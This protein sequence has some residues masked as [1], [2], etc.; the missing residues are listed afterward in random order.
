MG[1]SITRETHDKLE[2]RRAA[3][4]LCQGTGAH[5]TA[6]AVVTVTSEN[7]THAVGE[8]TPAVSDMR[9]C[10]RHARQ[11]PPGYAGVNFRV[12]AVNPVPGPAPKLPQR[13]PLAFGITYWGPLPGTADMHVQWDG[14]GSGLYL[15]AGN[16]ETAVVPG[17]PVRHESASGTFGTLREAEHALARFIAA[18]TE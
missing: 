9:M 11:F 12:L 7:W 8:G 14:P 6:R 18:G 16:P 3:G 10:P 15:Y 1:H 2:Q 17:V 4:E 13:H 5:C